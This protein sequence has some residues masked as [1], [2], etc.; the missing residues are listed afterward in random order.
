MKGLKV[1][2][3]GSPEQREIISS[4]EGTGECSVE[5]VMVGLGSGE[6]ILF[7]YG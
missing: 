7:G 2:C 6:W 5:G 1:K 4:G 3:C